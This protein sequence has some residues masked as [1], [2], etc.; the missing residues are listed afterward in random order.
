MAEEVKKVTDNHPL[1]ISIGVALAMFFYI[2]VPATHKLSDLKEQMA[3]TTTAA[4]KV[5][6]QV[7]EMRAEKKARKEDPL[8]LER[9]IRNDLRM[10]RAGEV[11]EVRKGALKAT[12][13]AGE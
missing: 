3:E 2:F 4:V 13:A 1:L 12:S 9:V 8:Y 11:S 7:A 5:S 10:V 6:S